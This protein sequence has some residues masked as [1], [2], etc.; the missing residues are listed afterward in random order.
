MLLIFVPTKCPAIGPL[1]D[2][3]FTFPVLQ[4]AGHICGFNETIGAQPARTLPP[5]APPAPRAARREQRRSAAV[6]DIF[7]NT[8]FR[9]GVLPA[10]IVTLLTMLSAQMF[11]WKRE[12]RAQHPGRLR[13]PAQ[14]VALHGSRLRARRRVRPLRPG[15]RPLNPGQTR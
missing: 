5:R 13:P 11:F 3:F 9:N 10:N 7:H 15:R 2:Q 4:P 14:A 8:S 6:A 12:A 1:T